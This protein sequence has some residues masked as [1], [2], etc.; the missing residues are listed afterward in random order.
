MQTVATRSEGGECC[1]VFAMSLRYKGVSSVIALFVLVMGGIYG[2]VFTA[3]EGAGDA[4]TQRVLALKARLGDLFRKAL[5]ATRTT[6]RAAPSL[7]ALLALTDDSTAALHWYC[8]A[9][10]GLVVI[11]RG[12]EAVE[13]ISLP[14]VTAGRV[15]KIA[16]D[17]VTSFDLFSAEEPWIYVT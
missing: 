15:G 10:G 9:S 17:G 12:R 13:V 2:G 1:A 16:V 6:A 14:R 11:V 3:V 8:E 4:E 5:F 7:A